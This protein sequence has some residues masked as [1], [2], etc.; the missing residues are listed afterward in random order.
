MPRSFAYL[1]A[2]AARLV[3]DPEPTTGPEVR[4]GGRVVLA[5]RDEAGVVG[6]RA[7]A[8]CVALPGTGAVMLADGPEETA[9]ADETPDADGAVGLCA[10]PVAHPASRQAAISPDRAINPDGTARTRPP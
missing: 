8:G 9:T 7:E 1:T 2:C 3:I 5:G 10:A 4:T 6:V